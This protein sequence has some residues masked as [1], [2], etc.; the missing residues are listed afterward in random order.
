M[1]NCSAPPLK[2][3]DV[4]PAPDEKAQRRDHRSAPVPIEAVEHAD[5]R[6]VGE[7]DQWLPDPIVSGIQADR[8]KRPNEDHTHPVLT[9][10]S[11]N[12][13]VR[14]IADPAQEAASRANNAYVRFCR[15]QR[16]PSKRR[17][18]SK[19]RKRGRPHV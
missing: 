12:E 2:D 10:N 14:V 1:E 15:A 6:R 8:K 16:G 13:T 9:S 11:V 3:H 17:G 4:G 7:R 18:P 19:K 5:A